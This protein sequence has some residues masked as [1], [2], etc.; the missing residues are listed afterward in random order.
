MP[1]TGKAEQHSQYL[2]M[3]FEDAYTTARSHCI[4]YGMDALESHVMAGVQCGAARLGASDQSHVARDLLSRL[5]GK[6]PDELVEEQ[7]QQ[8]EEEHS[9]QEQM[10]NHD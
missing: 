2:E 4:M 1:E 6:T 3:C 5:Y 10:L 9:R 7:R 8:A